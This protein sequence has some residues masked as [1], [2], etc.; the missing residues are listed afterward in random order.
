MGLAPSAVLIQCFCRFGIEYN[1][2]SVKNY[3]RPGRLSYT[4][5]KTESKEPNELYYFLFCIGV[6]DDCDR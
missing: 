6:V 4:I 5:V 3:L 2:L 1:L